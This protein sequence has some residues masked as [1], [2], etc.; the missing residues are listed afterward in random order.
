MARPGIAGRDV[1]LDV[2]IDGAA[3]PESTWIRVAG[4]A[5]LNVSGQ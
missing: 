4:L 2:Y 1:R 3:V 5:N